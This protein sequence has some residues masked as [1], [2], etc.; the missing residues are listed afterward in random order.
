[1]ELRCDLADDF[2]GAAIHGRGIHDPAAEGDEAR[3]H[4]FEW[5]TFRWI[6]TN[7]ENLPGAKTDDGKLFAG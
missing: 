6:R 7:V 2:F 4:L 1:M 5:L 3:Q